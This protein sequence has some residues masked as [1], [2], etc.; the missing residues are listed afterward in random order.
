LAT[1]VAETSLT[2]PRIGFVIDSGEARI[3]RYSVRSKVQRMPIERIAQASADQRMGRCGREGPGLCIRLYAEEDYAARPRFTDP[4]I[5]RTH[6][7]AVVLQMASLGL[8]AVEAFPFIDPP[9]RH[10]INDGYTTLFELGGVDAQRGLTRL[11][12]RLAQLS[13]DP[14]LARMLIAAHDE[15]A[16]AELLPIAAALA[17][18][19]PRERPPDAQ[20]AADKAHAAFAE[21]GSDFISLLHLWR[22]WQ[23]Q[24]RALSQSQLRKVAAQHYLSFVRM[25]EWADL[26]GQLRA[27]AR[28]LGLTINERAAAHANVHRALLAGL[29][30]NVA[31]HEGKGTYQSTRNRQV[32]IFPGSPV[33]QKPPKWLMAAEISETS[34]LF[35]RTVAAIDRA[36]V[37]RLAV[38]L[39]KRSYRNARWQP[40]S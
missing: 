9:E 38:H 27:Q 26:H 19:D 5:Q 22:F 10:L 2:G 20:G 18:Q 30:A 33:A 23:A 6:L 39:L 40:K 3:S 24:R 28:E 16:L 32:H 8:G 14:R 21:P 12:E 11:G 15:G 29:L 1:N 13:V 25:R 7:A 34:R 35:A 17:L 37:E 36:W 4:E 31:R